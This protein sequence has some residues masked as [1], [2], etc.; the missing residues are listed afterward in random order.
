VNNLK[1]NDSKEYVKERIAKQSESYRKT[2]NSFLDYNK[3]TTIE[4]N[5]DVSFLDILKKNNVNLFD[6]SAPE[7]KID[8]LGIN[9]K[10]LSKKAQEL[11]Y[12][13]SLF[14]LTIFYYENDKESRDYLGLNYSEM[15]NVSV[16][17]LLTTSNIFQCTDIGLENSNYT[18]E[19]IKQQDNKP[20]VIGS[21]IFGETPQNVNLNNTNSLFNKVIY[22][23]SK[24]DS[25][26]RQD[27]VRQERL[28]KFGQTAGANIESFKGLQDTTTLSN[29]LDGL[30]WFSTHKHNDIR[31]KVEQFINYYMF[32]Q[33]Y[34]SNNNTISQTQTKVDGNSSS[35]IS[36]ITDYQKTIMSLSTPTEIYSAMPYWVKARGLGLG[37]VFS[38]FSTISFGLVARNAVSD[39]GATE[40]RSISY[41]DL[42]HTNPEAIG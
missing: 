31:R 34:Q 32:S 20:I 5:E 41:N 4:D 39:I 30:Y 14:P 29:K 19:N 18:E 36:I 42:N 23:N 17:K 1:P 25:S 10:P 13:N 16:N 26:Y 27:F 7:T 21:N 2:Y 38:F 11:Y 9:I 24:T 37:S 8:D 33:N 3:N 28:K 22:E 35:N 6:A 15:K 40:T 12:A